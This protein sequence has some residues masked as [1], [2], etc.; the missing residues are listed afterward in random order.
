MELR[1]S[2][3]ARSL[4]FITAASPYQ[5]VNRALKYALMFLRIVFLTFFL[6]EATMGGRAHPA[7]YIL[8]GLTQVIFYLLVVALAEHIGF[9]RA[10]IG[11]ACA[12]VALSGYYASTVFH[13]I[14]RGF[15]ALTA[16]AGAYVLI[17]LLMKSE[18]Y[19][20]LIGS[21]TAFGAIALTM[22]VTRNLDWYGVSAPKE[23]RHAA[24][25]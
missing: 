12:T 3:Q 17:Y 6:I 20:L 14:V 13:S 4:G 9:E 7:Q 25:G 15:I 5:S 2:A 22:Y 11:T 23:E 18:D 21:V 10:F 1:A 24:H 19:A 16:F 8:L